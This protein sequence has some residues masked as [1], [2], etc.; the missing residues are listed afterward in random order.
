MH[1]KDW[2]N[3]WANECTN[4]WTDERTNERTNRASEQANEKK[5]GQTDWRRDESNE[6]PRREG[7]KRRKDE[8]TKRRTNEC[9][10]V[11][12]YELNEWAENKRT[13]KKTFWKH[14]TERKHS[15]N[16]ENL[17]YWTYVKKSVEDLTLHFHSPDNVACCGEQNSTARRTSIKKWIF[18]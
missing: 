18:A 15:N 8:G 12:I 17:I 2:L 3:E 7:A 9:R 6:A 5:K 1:P 13:N 10:C 11:R 16:K 14:L 4:I